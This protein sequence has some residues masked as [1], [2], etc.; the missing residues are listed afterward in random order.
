MAWSF[1]ESANEKNR[2]PAGGDLDLP[3]VGGV[4]KKGVARLGFG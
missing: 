3:A 1:V 2:L 4:W